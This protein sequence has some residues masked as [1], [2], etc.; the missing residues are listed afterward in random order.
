MGKKRKA[1]NVDSGQEAHP[2]R[3]GNVEEWRRRGE[4]ADAQ[5]H[6]GAGEGESTGRV[7]SQQF[8]KVMRTSDA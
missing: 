7:C 5:A 8:L 6:M 1:R 3:G 2:R 4:R